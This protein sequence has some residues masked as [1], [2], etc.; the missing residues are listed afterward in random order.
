M[1][2][3]E[4][5][6]INDPESGSNSYLQTI[7]R[8]VYIYYLCIINI[9]TVTIFGTMT[10]PAIHA[11][12][13]SDFIALNIINLIFLILEKQKF[14]LTTHKND[15]KPKPQTNMTEIKKHKNCNKFLLLS[16]AFDLQ[17]SQVFFIL[18]NL[19]F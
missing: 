4:T 17:H 16:A 18:I 8:C 11:R 7:E 1:S 10:F 6:W 14:P 12:H 15:T 13:Q 2:L 9:F 5:K 3:N 19:I